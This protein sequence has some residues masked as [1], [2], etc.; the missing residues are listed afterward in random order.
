MACIPNI[1]GTVES[2]DEEIPQIAGVHSGYYR[3]R[4][5]LENAFVFPGKRLPKVIILSRDGSDIKVGKTY[6][7]WAFSIGDMYE[8]EGHYLKD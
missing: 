3:S 4:I 7:F 1:V 2:I 6:S 8:D 5:V